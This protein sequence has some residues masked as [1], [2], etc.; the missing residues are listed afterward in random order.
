MFFGLM[1]ELLGY[2]EKQEK[3]TLEA[4]ERYNEQSYSHGA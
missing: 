1:T 2:L 4:P 3:L